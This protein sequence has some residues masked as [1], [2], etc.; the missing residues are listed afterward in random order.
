[1]EREEIVPGWVETVGRLLCAIRVSLFLFIEFSS[2]AMGGAQWQLGY[3]Y[4]W[5]VDLPVTVL[6]WWLPTP[7]GEAIIGPMWWYLIPRLLWWVCHK[8]KEKIKSNKGS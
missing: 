6:Y 4:I 5:I 8:V 7:I 3:M 2:P 1:M